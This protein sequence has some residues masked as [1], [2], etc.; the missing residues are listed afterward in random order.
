MKT[1]TIIKNVAAGIA[2]SAIAA[3]AALQ[4]T[5]LASA[6]NVTSYW[7]SG[8]YAAAIH[9]AP[10]SNAPVLGLGYYPDRVVMLCQSRNLDWMLTRNLRTGVTGWTLG[11][12]LQDTTELPPKC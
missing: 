4:G 11:Q 8:G 6:A 7:Y 2:G 9:S 1:R 3:V 10:N 12:E 5:G